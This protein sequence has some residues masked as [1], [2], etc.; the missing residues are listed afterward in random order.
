MRS[1]SQGTPLKV[2]QKVAYNLSGDVVHGIIRKV[3]SIIHIEYI[4]P[5]RRTVSSRNHISKVKSNRSILV[6]EDPDTEEKSCPNC[7]Q[8]PV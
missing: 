5:G 4:R 6:L 8:C 1:D 3:G 7:G 2:G